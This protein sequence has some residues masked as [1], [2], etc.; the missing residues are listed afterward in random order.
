MVIIDTEKL[1]NKLDEMGEETVRLR[2]VQGV[3]APKQKIDLVKHWLSEREKGRQKYPEI[4]LS[5]EKHLMKPKSNKIWDDIHNDYDIT[6][7]MFGKRIN[8]VKDEF[9]RKVIF[10]D[11]EHAYILADLGFSKPAVILAGSVIE[12]MLRMYLQHKKITPKSKTF[13]AYIKA[14]DAHGL[15]KDAIQRLTD[16]VRHFRN[17]VHLSK[18]KSKRETISKATAKGAVSSIFTIA[19]DF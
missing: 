15:L 3:F 16:S 18:E 8:F 1:F 7:R 14:C 6:K 19:N 12:E 10:R 11:V 5:Q 13:D 2:L 9:K 17:L 4:N